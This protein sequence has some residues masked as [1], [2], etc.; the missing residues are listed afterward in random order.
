MP[1]K[2]IERSLFL[3]FLAIF[4]LMVVAFCQLQAATYNI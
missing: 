4:V 1:M 2:S 3:I